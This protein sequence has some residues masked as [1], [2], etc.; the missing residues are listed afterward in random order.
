MRSAH[1]DQRCSTMKYV[2]ANAQ[3]TENHHCWPSTGS[4]R[5]RGGRSG[6]GSAQPSGNWLSGAQP[7]THGTPS[8]R[9]AIAGAQSGP[10]GQ[11][12]SKVRRV[13]GTGRKIGQ[14]S[15]SAPITIG[16]TGSSTSTSPQKNQ[17]SG[18]SG[19]GSDMAASS[20]QLPTRLTSTRQGRECVACIEPIPAGRIMAAPSHCRREGRPSTGAPDRGR[21]L[22]RS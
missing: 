12:S 4:T 17:L 16:S 11:S 6:S 8:E 5:H 7:T 21:C 2:L 9:R 10:Q 14:P 15:A 19:S 20:P 13:Q 18:G 3:S 1:K 22:P